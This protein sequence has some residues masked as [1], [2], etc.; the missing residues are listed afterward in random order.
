[1][2]AQ[3]AQQYC[4]CGTQLAKDNTERQCARCQRAT[5]DKLIAPPQVPSEFWQTDQFRDA[6][7]AQHIG[8]VARFYRTHPYHHAIYG[9][10][11]ISQTLLGQWLGLRQPQVSQIETGPS[12]RDLDTLTYW[13]RT[14]RIPA[15]LLWFDMP[16]QALLPPLMVDGRAASVDGTGNEG[17][18]TA[19]AT[20]SPLTVPGRPD[21]T[22][23]LTAPPEQAV[24]YLREQWH[25]L[26]RA[27]NLFG[28]ARVLRLVH[29][30]I[31]LVEAILWQAPRTLRPSL[32]SLGAKYAESAAWL[33]EDA[34][35]ASATFWTGR[36]LEWAQAADDERLVAWAL[37][38]RSQQVAAERDASQ[39]VGLAQA[40]RDMGALSAQMRA[41]ITQQEAY[42][43]ALDGN[44]AACQCALDDA[45][46]WAAAEDTHGDARS[47]HGAFCTESY[48]ELK[49]AECWQTLG[50]PQRAVPTYQ[51]ALAG[52][53]EAYHRGHGLAYL[54]GALVAIDEP[55]PAANAAT[56]AL[57]IASS[58]G[59]G[60]TL[61]RIRAVARQL[62]PHARLPAVAQLFAALAAA[63][64]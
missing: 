42:G 54:A 22:V 30:Q 1:M 12:I 26:V 33:H 47:G 15:G 61:R 62:R 44:E 63:G 4:R 53:P 37:F 55:E 23:W 40:A 25:L 10:S 58:C 31:E 11:G 59:S 5:R 46:G 24:A 49:R 18:R 36:A 2:G 17:E 6:F 16:G 52:L 41:A 64:P 39:A 50:Q 28:P 19:E 34:G 7:A 32:L 51:T 38:R 56:E 60:R 21:N 48:I 29:A 9:S 43:L 13:A 45:L 35:E 27:D 3:R 20:T 8:R 57:A 14:L